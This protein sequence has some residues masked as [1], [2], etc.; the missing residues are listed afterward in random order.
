N[1]IAEES[2]KSGLW[3]D[4][5]IKQAPVLVLKG[6]NMPAVEIEMD[7]LTSPQGEER[8]MDQW[9]QQRICEVFYRAI[10]RFGYEF[11][12]DPNGTEW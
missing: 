3:R 4:S 1:I 9:H 7:F 11:E 6:A 10:I 5:V 8:L 2:R 12:G